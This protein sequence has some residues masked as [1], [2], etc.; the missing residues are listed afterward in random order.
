MNSSEHKQKNRN[1][2]IIQGV[3][4]N[5]RAVDTSGL[6]R[7]WNAIR[8]VSPAVFS[9]TLCYS[10]LTDSPSLLLSPNGRTFPPLYNT[11]SHHHWF[12]NLVSNALAIVKA[13]PYLLSHHNSKVQEERIWPRLGQVLPRS[14]THGEFLP[15]LNLNLIIKETLRKIQNVEHS[16]RQMAW[17]L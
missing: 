8:P 15:K 5:L 16:I 3:S 12:Q 4:W 11:P 1:L 2:F 9:A 10:F 7:V 6:R 14:I 17:T 13:W